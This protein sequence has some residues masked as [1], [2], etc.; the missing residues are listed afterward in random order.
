MTPET[1]S[2]IL[3]LDE[4]IFDII[5]FDEASQIFVE[6]AIPAIYRAKSIVVAGDDKQLQPNSVAKKKLDVFDEI[7]GE[8]EIEEEFEEND[9][10]VLDEVSL[11]DVAKKMYKGALLSYHYRSNYEELIN[12][13]NYAF[14]KGRL[15]I[16]PNRENKEYLPIERIKVEGIWENRKF[17]RSRRNL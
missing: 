2:D 3:P 16:A 9:S 10:I 6:K 13:S 14:Y 1:V 8:E 4:N 12:F 5:I 17:K 15:I 7:E 11:L